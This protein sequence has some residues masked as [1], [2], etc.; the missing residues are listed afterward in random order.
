MWTTGFKRQ[1]DS[2]EWYCIMIWNH[3]TTASSL[4]KADP[5]RKRQAKMNSGT[6]MLQNFTFV[7]DTCR[8]SSLIRAPP[9]NTTC[10]LIFANKQSSPSKIRVVL[11]QQHTLNRIQKHLT[12]VSLSSFKYLITQVPSHSEHTTLTSQISTVAWCLRNWSLFTAKIIKKMYKFTL[13]CSKFWEKYLGIRFRKYFQI[14][15][16]MFGQ[17]LSEFLCYGIPLFCHKLDII[18][19][20]VTVMKGIC[21]WPDTW[22]TVLLDRGTKKKSRTFGQQVQLLQHWEMINWC[23]KL[24]RKNIKIFGIK[25]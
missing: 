21:W 22:K 10:H 14:R 1:Q 24:R 19:W 6:D 16:L 15:F 17:M 5:C 4:D 8:C 23:N 25:S 7:N 11:M 9:T 3:L 12:L 18:C 13:S 2:S 20:N